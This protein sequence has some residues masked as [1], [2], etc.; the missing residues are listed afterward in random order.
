[1]C[2]YVNTTGT[3]TCNAKKQM[4]ICTVRY[5]FTTS[6][7]KTGYG[8]GTSMFIKCIF[9]IKKNNLHVVQ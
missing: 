4:D 7:R 3:G 9:G 1:M 2:T 5:R 8:T 6:N